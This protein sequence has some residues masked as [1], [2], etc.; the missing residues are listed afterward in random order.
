M[1]EDSTG[2]GSTGP[3]SLQTEGKRDAN[4]SREALRSTLME[5]AI[6]LG[7]ARG[8]AL[9]AV[10]LLAELPAPEPP[11]SPLVHYKTDDGILCQPTTPGAYTAVRAA[12]LVTC[13]L[14]AE[15]LEAVGL[16]RR[17]SPSL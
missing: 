13:R 8:A 10:Q 12:A 17:R 3:Q 5:L 9:L 11:L 6:K 2:A 1:K 7:E 15:Q 16:R 4:D 14:C